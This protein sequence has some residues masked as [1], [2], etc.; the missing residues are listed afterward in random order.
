MGELIQRNGN[1]F[2]APLEETIL[3][4]NSETGLYHGL[5]LVAARIWEILADPIEEAAL[6]AQLVAE[7]EVTPEDCQREVS[8]FLAGLRARGLLITTESCA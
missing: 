8:A 3:L 4:L 1:V 5:N 7:F 6:I 2:V